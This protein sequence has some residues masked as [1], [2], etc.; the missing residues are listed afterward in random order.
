[1]NQDSFLS[2]CSDASLNNNLNF[3][4]SDG[5]GSQNYTAWEY[6]QD[7]YYPTVIRENYPVYI[8]E[9]A[10]DKAKQAYEIVKILKDKKLVKLEKV[11]NFIDLMD[12]LIKIL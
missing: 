10:K 7:Y 3:R 11:A 2:V 6:W 12:E 1:M 5:T 4:Y 8:Q 9:R